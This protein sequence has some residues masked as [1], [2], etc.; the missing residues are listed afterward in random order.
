MKNQDGNRK[1]KQFVFNWYPLILFIMGALSILWFII[2]PKTTADLNL[3]LVGF[4]GLIS[5]FYFVLK[6][7]SEELELFTRLFREFNGRYDKL[8]EDLNRIKADTS[9]DEFSKKDENLLYDYFNLCSEEYLYYKRGFIYP[10]VWKAWCNGIDYFLEN[11]RIGN[12]WDEEEKNA[13]SY[14]GLTRKEIESHVK[15]KE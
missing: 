11:K 10:E 12:L 5:F 4:G 1:I 7:Q 2:S 3:L 13:A 9:E 8:N 14:Y 15:G 6:Q